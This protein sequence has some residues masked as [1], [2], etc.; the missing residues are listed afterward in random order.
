[1]QS[2]VSGTA[3][4]GGWYGFSSCLFPSVDWLVTDVGRGESAT[5]KVA[6]LGNSVYLAGYT[7]GNHS[8]RSSVSSEM[9]TRVDDDSHFDMHI[10][11]VSTAGV[12]TRVWAFTGTDRTK[13]FW[14]DVH[15][16]ADGTHLA[17]G[18]R[19]G[20]NLTVP[21]VGTLV[22]SGS[23][24]MAFVVKLN[25][26]SGNV[27]WMR[28]FDAPRGTT[29][30]GVDGDAAGNM[31]LTYGTCVVGTTPEMS[32]GRPTGRLASACTYNVAKLAAAD[33][34]TIWSTALPS[35]A[36]VGTVRVA[37][38]GSVYTAGR[39]SGSATF[40]TQLL[41]VSGPSGLVIKLDASGAFVDAQALASSIGDMDLSSDGSMLAVM[42][43]LSG[44]SF[45]AT[46]DPS[47]GQVLWQGSAP[48]LRGVEITDDNQYVVVYGQVTG[49]SVSY[50]VTD[51]LGHS[52]TLR[53]YGSYDLFVMKMAASDGD[54]VW[55]INGG[56]DG[57]A[58]KSGSNAPSVDSPPICRQTRAFES[59]ADSGVLLGHG[60]G[61]LG[62]HLHLGL[63]AL[64]H[65]HLW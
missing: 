14:S 51:T 61:R 43:S 46:I 64:E 52:T 34:S 63:L 7:T 29:I 23:D 26:A 41:T 55:A 16:F 28:S 10:T 37:A 3:S 20:G 39:V 15:K 22:N 9:I 53:S 49:S 44:G 24:P 21:G 50:T 2:Q 11:E 18:G 40:G 6:H 54:G 1:M 27:A 31:I 35:E 56:G 5:Q 32:Y 38:D 4:S 47:N 59:R 25:T 12:P 8:V 48:Y 62:R 57:S 60:D 30:G 45:V 33:G 36:T 19:F 58:L 65:V 17:A 42:G 13:D